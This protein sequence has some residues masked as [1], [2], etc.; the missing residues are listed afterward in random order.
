MP[1]LDLRVSLAGLGV[2]SLLFVPLFVCVC[3]W[4]LWSW[5]AFCEKMEPNWGELVSLFVWAF[6]ARLCWCSAL[7]VAVMAS[8]GWTGLACRNWW[9]GMGLCHQALPLLDW[10]IGH[11][12]PAL[13]LELC[14]IGKVCWYLAL[15]YPCRLVMDWRPGDVAWAACLLET[16][17][18]ALIALMKIVWAHLA[19]VGA[20]GVNRFRRRRC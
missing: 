5:L 4:V 15:G 3:A 7:L 12:S 16:P 10:A 17:G 8:R 6:F 9:P 2:R 14:F 18:G 1:G 11:L 13:K 20:L 19:F